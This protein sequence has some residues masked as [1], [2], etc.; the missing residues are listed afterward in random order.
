MPADWPALPL[1]IVLFLAIIGGSAISTAGGIKYYRIGGMVTLSLQELRRL[2]YP[3]GIRAHGSGSVP[4]NLELMKSIWSSIVI[5]LF[6]VVVATLLI[7]I[8]EPNFDGALTAAVAAFS[9]IGP[10]YS[11]GWPG[12]D[13]WPAY[14]DFG[15]VRQDRHDRDDDSWPLR[16]AGVAWRAQSL[17]LAVLRC[18]ELLTSTVAT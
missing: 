17:L 3:H 14:A 18:P 11:A 13:A 1:P 16:G 4:Y 2:V 5:S 9:N 6:V 8:T 15:V 10:L 12:G 7:A